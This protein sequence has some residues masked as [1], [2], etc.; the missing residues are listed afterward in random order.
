LETTTLIDNLTGGETYR[1]SVVA[2]N[3][4]GPGEEQ[5]APS[6][7]L[8]MPLLAPP[9]PVHHPELVL[10]TVHNSDFSVQYNA[11]LFSDKHGRITRLLVIV[12]E[13]DTR[14]L[15]MMEISN[16]SSSSTAANANS[17]GATASEAALRGSGLA[18]ASFVSKLL[19]FSNEQSSLLISKFIAHILRTKIL[20]FLGFLLCPYFFA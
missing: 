17:G 3:D 8:R 4:A 7:E 6:A 14:D 9:R 5:Q 15:A 12:S 2:L 16:G 18:N 10:G 1:V 11:A 20:D 19:L 13:V